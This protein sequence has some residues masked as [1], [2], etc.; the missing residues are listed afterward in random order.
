MIKK[1]GSA[2]STLVTELAHE[3]L[4]DELQELQEDP[5]CNEQI[6]KNKK[7][8]F[9]VKLKRLIPGANT[10]LSAILGEDGKI[11]TDPA[12][13]ATMLIKHW[14]D[15]FTHRPVDLTLLDHWRKSLPK[16]KEQ[17]R[18]GIGTAV[19]QETGR[20]KDNKS[21]KVVEVGHRTRH[22]NGAKRV[23]QATQQKQRRAPQ[24]P[25][26]PRQRTEWKSWR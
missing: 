21:G 13:M 18:S 16:Q 23:M 17:Q 9:G 5:D 11:H 8:Q 19:G 14:Q 6:K 26:F 24:S 12:A 2:L 7:T 25:T 1:T 10:S 4:Q 20:D 22:N 15:V 3:Q